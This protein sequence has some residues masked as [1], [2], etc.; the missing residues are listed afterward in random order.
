MASTTTARTTITIV[1]TVLLT[2]ASVLAAGAA[3]ADEAPRAHTSSANLECAGQ[4]ATLVGTPGDDTIV[5]TPRADVIVGLGGNDSVVGRGGADKICGG[6][7]NDT[8]RG[9]AGRDALAGGPGHDRLLGGAGRDRSNGGDGRDVCR[10]PGR[11]GLL[12]EP[13]CPENRNPSGFR[14]G[15]LRAN[16]I[17]TQQRTPTCF[18]ESDF[19]FTADGVLVA[20]HDPGMG[21]TCGEVGQK[22]LRDLRT[23]RLA[24]GYR[25][26]TLSEFLAVPLTEW[27]IDLKSNKLA[28]SDEEIFRTAEAAVRDIVAQ[29]RQ[30]GA[31]LFLYQVTPAVVELVHRHGIRAG[32]KGYPR[33]P[34]AA[35]AMVDLAHASRFD[36]VCIR[37]AHIDRAM[38]A[39]SA[40]RG[41]WHLGWEL[42]ERTPEQ[43]RELRT[44]GLGGLL[45]LRNRVGVAQETMLGS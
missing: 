23:C 38:L 39:Y 25:V 32:I 27:Y 36:V 33:S 24:N 22:T 6:A 14:V 9:G 45:S 20:T 2:S 44:Q 31:V 4:R 12:C 8:L 7:G 3:T 18:T 30:R 43:W 21:G 26:T 13:Y 28:S 35:R 10:S 37:I 17:E 1:V 15:M 40:A 34:A 41:V 19:M 29:K 42:G 16:S 5:G 11:T